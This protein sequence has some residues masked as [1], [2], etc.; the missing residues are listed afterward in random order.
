MDSGS[1]VSLLPH[2][3]IA[4]RLNVQPLQ[5][6]A[7][8]QL[9]IRTY[10][11]SMVKLDLGLR[12]A[13]AWTFIVADVRDTILG[14]D[15]L[16]H[17]GLLVDMQK[18]RLI[19]TLTALSVPAQVQAAAVYSI[20]AQG[21]SQ[22]V[23]ETRRAYDKLL[24]EFEDIT[25]PRL[26]HATLNGAPVQHA[27]HTSGPPVFER[28]RR[29]YGER[30]QAAQELF[31]NLQ[32]R[33]IVRS[34][35][36]Q[37]TSPLH[38]VD[39]K[40]GGHRVTGDYRR[41][42]ASTLPDRYP[43]P[44]IEDLLQ[45]CYGTSVFSTIHLEKAFYQVP[46][47][48]EDICKTAIT[49]PFGMFEFLRMPLGLRNGT[50]TFQRFMDSLLR[51]LPF[52]HCYLDDIIVTSHS[53]EEHLQHLCT[54][55]QVLQRAGLSIE[56]GKCVFGRP[57]LDFLGHTISSRRFQPP[58]RKVEAIS[59]YPKP[60]D[61]TQLRRFLG[62]VNHYRRSIPR[63]AQIQAPLNQLLVGK[64]RTK[65]FAIQWPTAAEAAFQACKQAI[66]DAVANTFLSPTASLRVE[67]DDPRQIPCVSARPPRHL[68]PRL[69]AQRHSA[70]TA[71]IHGPPRGGQKGQ[72]Q[73]LRHQGQRS[74]ETRLH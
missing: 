60:T 54:L 11:Q 49:T 42:N 74:G 17:S 45:E 58:Q 30:L 39:R 24:A 12:R 44:V 10:G 51:K 27:I 34:S 68:Q 71:A 63:A 33:G 2:T 5:L 66:K 62:M 52:A 25:K 72:R 26:Q 20:A 57:E 43:I 6:M 59:R 69:P 23:I 7:A 41:L 32:D 47:A 8:N 13:F 29:L 65:R 22:Q 3:S 15:F 70:Q 67:S 1:V 9:P 48:E 50:Q 16:I 36:R 28:P 73:G 4:Q 38:M 40:D 37:W 53:D 35:S 31:R 55:F 19:D 56:L 64:G 21:L 14:A 46:M 18:K 61:S